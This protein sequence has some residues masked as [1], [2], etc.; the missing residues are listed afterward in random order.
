[1]SGKLEGQ[2]AIV[3]GGGRGIGRAIALVLARE[4]ATVV[5]ASRTVSEVERTVADIKGQGGKAIAVPTDVMSK[6]SV[7]ALVAATLAETK[8]IDIVINNAG[9]FVWKGFA[10]LEEEEWDRILATNLKSA[11]LLTQAA[12]PALT[13]SGKG[14]VVNISSIHGLVGDANF[15]A[16]C[17]AKFGLIGLTKALAEELR[18]VGIRVN[19]V[20]PG[21]TDNKN[22]DIAPAARAKPLKEIL[23]ATDIAEAV[24][25]LASPAAAAITGSV[26]D[27]WG[28]TTAAVKTF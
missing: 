1:M 5:I 19:A 2:T 18:E 23:N 11:Y 6:K 10:Q 15:T 9:I 8:R 3:T 14:N 17:A 7:D 28:G 16:H 21:Q 22:L 27:V 26:I 20:N 12:L 25:F 24:L 13:N 4:G